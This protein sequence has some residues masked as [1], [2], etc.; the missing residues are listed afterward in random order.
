MSNT[1]TS[2]AVQEKVMVE[3][4]R[5]WHIVFYNDNKTTFEVV[6]FILMLVFEKSPKESHELTVRVH[7]E[8]KAVVAS[9]PFDIAEQKLSEAI[10]FARDHG[11]PLVIKMEQ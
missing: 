3:E 8:G 11:A 4:I 10:K 5:P 6:M 7:N 1:E 2:E 9:Y